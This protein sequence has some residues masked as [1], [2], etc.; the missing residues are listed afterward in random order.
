MKFCPK[1]MKVAHAKSGHKQAVFSRLRCKE[2]S[3]DF[4]AT[5]NA[6]LWRE[7]LKKRLPEISQEWYLITLTAHSEKRTRQQSMENIRG[8]LDKLYKRIRRVFGPIEYVR[9]YE[10][11]PT[12]EAVHA[13]LI[14][15][16]LSPFV[17]VGC[18][19]K[20]QPMAIG[21]VARSGRNGVWAIKTWFKKIAQECQMGYMADVQMIVGEPIRCVWYV[22]KYLTKAVQ[23]IHEKGLRH[24]Q[25]TK[26]IG[27]PEHDKQSGWEVCS[28]ITTYTFEAG[29]SV[30]D[31]NTGDVIDNNYWEFHGFY[32]ND[33]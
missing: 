21:V 12:S 31:L 2:W 19:S 24:V 8:N 10:K 6:W 16:G 25:V 1:Y 17:A 28:Y 4:C 29:T 11:H 26:G 23:D 20:L 13:H 22:T 15:S 32:P 30:L 33:Q 9:V 7:H 3:C 5:R 14:M 18:S 27:S